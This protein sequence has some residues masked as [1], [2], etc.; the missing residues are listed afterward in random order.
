MGFNIK[1]YTYEI[2]NSSKEYEA[3]LHLVHDAYPTYT[4]IITDQ[5]EFNDF[6][7]YDFKFEDK[8]ENFITEEELNVGFVSQNANVIDL[9]MQE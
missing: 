3:F 8:K 5:D 6:R 7:R 4:P 9:T 2:L 1:S